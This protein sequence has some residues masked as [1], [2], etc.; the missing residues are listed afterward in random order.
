MIERETSILFALISTP[1]NMSRGWEWAR[2]GQWG[3]GGTYIMLSTIQILKTNK[4]LE[5]EC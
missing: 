2:M 4:Q 5:G 1:L 3:K